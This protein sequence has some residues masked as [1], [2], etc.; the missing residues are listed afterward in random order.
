MIL[1]GGWKLLSII[2][3]LSNAD[4]AIMGEVPSMGGV[5]VFEFDCSFLLM[6][7]CFE[8]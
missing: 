5:W 8:F 3:F 2:M 7:L 1:L 4:V 6:I